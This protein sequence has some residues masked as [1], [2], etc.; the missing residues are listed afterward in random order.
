MASSV[1]FL[2]LSCRQAGREARRG[3]VPELH[4][5]VGRQIKAG[6]LLEIVLPTVAHVC[7]TLVVSDVTRN[8]TLARAVGHGVAFRAI[9]TA[10]FGLC[11]AGGHE[12]GRQTHHIGRHLVERH[13]WVSGRRALSDAEHHL[14]VRVSLVEVVG[15]EPNHVVSAQSGVTGGDC[16]SGAA[17]PISEHRLALL[18]VRLNQC[19]TGAHR[20]GE[21]CASGH[22]KPLNDAVTGPLGADDMPMHL[23]A[24]A[25]RF[26]VGTNA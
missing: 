15:A 6:V 14:I 4:Q 19:G 17:R 26:R 12:H 10:R 23:R 1:G 24:D 22:G 9:R 20:V 13:V 25:L 2:G 7:G 5:P 11:H 16:G 21:P 8:E 3:G 18:A